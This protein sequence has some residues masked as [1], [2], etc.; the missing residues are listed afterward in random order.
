MIGGQSVLEG[1]VMKGPSKSVMS[2]RMPDG[3]I[4]SDEIKDPHLR[5]KYPILALP[6]IRGVV[7]MIESLVSGYKTLMKSADMLGIEEDDEPTKLDLFVKKVTKGKVTDIVGP[8]SMVLGMVLAIA[9]FAFLPA[10]AAKYLFAF[11]PVGYKGIVEGLMRIVIFILYIALVGLM[12]DIKRT[13]EY[14]GAEHKTI[15]CYEAGEEL[16][17]ENARKFTRFHPRCGTSFLFLMLLISILAF[18]FL[19]WNSILI[20]ILLK[21]LCLPLIIGVG[22]ELIRYAGGHDN[23]FTKII[24]APGLWMQRL[25]TREPDDGELEVAITALKQVLPTDQEDDTW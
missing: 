6:I 22:F 1:I 21:L 11:I 20:R 4:K 12:K 5:Q 18:S 3:T 23:L 19:T 17:V 14:H 10:V 24:S 16:T 7:A 15:A 9:I 2:L 8:I 25:V 13:Y